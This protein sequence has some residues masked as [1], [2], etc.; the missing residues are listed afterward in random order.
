MEIN[1]ILRKKMPKSTAAAI[2]SIALIALLLFTACTAPTPT[3]SVPPALTSEP[4]SATSAPTESVPPTLTA[5]P[6]EAAPAEAPTASLTPRPAVGVEFDVTGL[7]NA[8]W[9]WSESTF[10]GG[11]VIKVND[12]LRYTIQFLA[13]GTLRTVAD[14]NLASGSYVLGENIALSLEVGA[15]TKM[16]CP[17]DSQ[18]GEFAFELA[19]VTSYNIEDGYLILALTADGGAMKFTPQ[20]ILSFPEPPPGAAA[21]STTANTLVRLGPD[22]SNPIYGILPAGAQAEIVG[23]YTPWWALRLPGYPEGIGWVAQ[24]SVRAENYDN[25]PSLPPR[26]ADYGRS[27][28][29]PRLDDPSVLLTDPQLILA[30]P[31]ETYPVVSAALTGASLFVIGRNADSTYWKVYLPPEVVPAASGWIPASASARATKVENVPVVPVLTGASATRFPKGAADGP[32]AAP[33]ITINLR[34]GPGEDF[35]VLDFAL[36]GQVMAITG[37]T[38][39]GMWLQVSVSPSISA[40]RSAWIMEPNVY[41]FSPGSVQ[42]VATPLPGW[43][44]T[45]VT[46]STCTLLY[47]SPPNGKVFK[48]NQDF[49]AEFEVMNNTSKSWSRGDVDLTFVAALNSDPMHTGSDAFD[50]E[51][52]VLP[53]QSY[54]FSFRITTPFDSGDFSEVWAITRGAAPIC[55]FSYSI[56]INPPPPTPTFTYWPTITGTIEPTPPPDVPPTPTKGTPEPTNPPEVSPTPRY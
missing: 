56:H 24:G 49:T 1:P 46:T 13:D 7:G 54:R 41:I 55:S 10:N 17:P 42:V 15:M 28:P 39:D 45:D 22:A 19:D 35:P 36:K 48:P 50:L 53:G 52:T 40:T 27:F 25:A 23:K 37:R 38:T 51:N 32:I 29:L 47:Q 21:A 26:L 18:S 43:I 8:L 9:T 31:G 14:C 33:Y 20:T 4:L 3:E 6:T 12:P 44:P 2:R 16:A 11:K 30:G 34:S 5:T